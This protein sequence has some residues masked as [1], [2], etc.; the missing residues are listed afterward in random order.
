MK[1][2]QV[3]VII[4]W[5]F[6]SYFILLY[7][8]YLTLNFIALFALPRYMQ[9]RI[10]HELPQTAT[11]FDIPISIVL[12]AY[13][14]EALIVS[15]VRS[16]LQLTYS[17][18]E[19]VIGNDGSKDETLEV[20]K[21]EFKLIRFPEAYRV[22]LPTAPVRGIYVSTIYPNLR[23]ID[24][25]NGGRS[26]TLNATINAARYPLICVIDA[27]SV[28]ERDSLHRAAQPFLDDPRTVACGGMIRIANGCQVRG[29]CM[30]RAGLP[31]NFLAL[32]QVVEYLRAFLFGRIGWSTV[33][34]LL[35]I[36]GAFG[37]FH[38]ESVI[39][40]GGY[41][42][43]TIAE[44]MDLTMRLHRQ[45]IE[46]GVP[47][48]ISFIPDPVLWTEGPEDFKTLHS[49]RVR[50]QYGLGECIS[51]N[52][53]LLFKRGSGFA[54]WVAMP[55]N[56]MLEWIGPFVEAGGYV[57][58]F[59][60]YM[61]GL[62]SLQSFVLFFLFAIGLGMIL[63]VSSLLL[64]E[65]SFHTYP[66][67]RH[68]IVLFVASLLENLGY[69]QLNVLWRLE[70]LVRWLIGKKPGWGRMTRTAAWQSETPS[71]QIGEHELAK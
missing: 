22:R 31:T 9:L 7:G 11:E 13:N 1:L 35:L 18:F 12:A 39:S 41:N 68:I 3:I 26:D 58:M 53:E 46:Q 2:G 27:D 8:G 55:F 16:L 28:M 36:S 54:G 32:F 14:E 23:V 69:R 52:R 19:L 4:E 62:L 60:M 30:E 47:Y 61:F 10:I 40:A 37:V 71:E 64:E 21:R 38:K 67:M 45:A 44:D 63:S 25:E 65:L 6:V 33:N 51:L 50:W 48:K 57:F 66:K 20:L 59:V 49:Q 34:G 56:L 29:G 15:S 24:K 42:I 5:L 17:E 43:D 70:G